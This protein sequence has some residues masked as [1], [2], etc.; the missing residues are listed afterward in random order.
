VNEFEVEAYGAKDFNFGE[1]SEL[2]SLSVGAE[3]NPMP[4]K[5]FSQ[6]LATRQNQAPQGLKWY[7]RRP[8]HHIKP[9]NP[10]STGF[11]PQIPKSA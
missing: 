4:V 7:S 8:A 6:N 1:I 11:L 3:K 10:K 9:T 2:S 5:N